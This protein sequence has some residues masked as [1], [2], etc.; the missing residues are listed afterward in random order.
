MKKLLALGAVVVAVL[1]VIAA[2]PPRGGRVDTRVLAGVTLSVQDQF[3]RD[4]LPVFV[5]NGSPTP[6]LIT[7]TWEG[8]YFVNTITNTIG[9]PNPTNNFARKFAF[10]ALGT[11]TFFLSN[12]AGG[13]LLLTSSNVVATL[14]AI[15]SNRMSYAWSTGTNWVV[16]P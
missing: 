1:I 14:V 10:M 2:D 12:G 4:G 6:F 9:L 16:L 3:Y 11:N 5:T 15:N 8:Q 13:G 7:N